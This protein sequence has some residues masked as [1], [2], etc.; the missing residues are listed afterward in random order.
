MRLSFARSTKKSPLLPQ[1]PRNQTI[2]WYWFFSSFFFACI[3]ALCSILLKCK[4]FLSCSAVGRRIDLCH[5]RGANMHKLL[6]FLL[7]P[8]LFLRR[9]CRFGYNDFP[10]P[11]HYDLS[12][13]NPCLCLRLD[14]GIENR[15]VCCAAWLISI[16]SRTVP[17]SFLFPGSS[18]CKACFP[19]FSSS[20]QWIFIIRRPEQR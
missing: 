16:F 12:F 4:K 15:T 9:L 6:F 10:L 17:S 13:L 5:V 11:K 20:I 19:F 3:W 8:F 2:V 14:F 1:Y 18:L 7:F